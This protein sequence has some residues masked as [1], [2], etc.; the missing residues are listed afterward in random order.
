MSSIAMRRFT[1]GPSVRLK[2]LAEDGV[3][4]VVDSD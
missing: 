2:L 1:A 4:E 3:I